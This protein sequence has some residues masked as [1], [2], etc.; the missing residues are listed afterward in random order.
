MRTHAKPLVALASGVILLAGMLCQTTNAQLVLSGSATLADTLGANSGP[1]AL[2]VQYQVFLSGGIYFYAYWVNNPA[3]DVIL[4]NNGSPTSTP[5]IV[6]A[7]SVAF[8]TTAPGAYIAGSIAGGTSTQ[9]NGTSGLFWSFNAISPG[10]ST[11]PSNPLVFESYL[12]PIMGNANAQDANPP[13][14]WSSNPNGQ[15]VPVPNV[16]IPE[17]AT[18]TLFALAALLLLPFRSNM[19]QLIRRQANA[20]SAQ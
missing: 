7:Y 20:S 1:E 6:D 9:D 11:P 13:S 8:D 12:P 3:G 4:N 14:P 19:L 5:E 16:T 17:P 2:T 10:G 15:Q 18:T